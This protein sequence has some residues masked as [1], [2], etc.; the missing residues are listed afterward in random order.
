MSDA[1]DIASL[2]RTLLAWYDAEGRRLPWR[3]R[4]EDRTAG[5]LVSPYAIWLSEIMLKQTTIPH[6]TPYWF[7][8]LELWPEVGDLAAAPRE[9]VMRE[10]AGLGYYARARNLHACAIAVSEELG[11]RFPDTL[12]GLRALPGI[13]EYTANAILAAAFDKPASVVDGNVERVITRL[14]RVE[15]EMPKAKPEIR[16]LA[17]AIADP[18]RPCDYAQ[19]IMDLGATVCTPRSPD[20]GGCPWRSGCEACASGDAERY[21][22]KAPKKAKPVRRGTAWLVRR[23]GHVWLRRRA[24][25]GLLGGMM[26]VPSTQWVE[27]DSPPGEAEAPLA[28]AD[29]QECGEIRHVFTHFELRLVV[30]EAQAPADWEPD[31]GGW[32]SEDALGQE[33]L[34]SVMRKVVAVRGSWPRTGRGA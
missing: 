4:P 22:R 23:D 12:E 32:V 15:T 7:R 33:A 31:A 14:H 10:W 13:G 27:A 5:R 20:C 16:R 11:G 3:I 17:A 34:P 24:D 9:H 26:E 19:A 2:R 18:D 25:K 30:R 6:A 29:W 8:F 1:P 28:A 21:P